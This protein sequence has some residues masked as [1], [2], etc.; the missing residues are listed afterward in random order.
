MKRFAFVHWSKHET[1]VL[2][3]L[4]TGAVL[5]GLAWALGTTLVSCALMCAWVA[6]A[7]GP[8]YNLSAF[9]TAGSIIG[10][11]AGGVAGGKASGAHGSLHGLMVGLL[12]G[13]LLVALFMAGSAWS[14]AIAGMLTRA[15]LLGIIGAAGGLFGV[16]MHDRGRG[17][18]KRKI[19][20]PRDF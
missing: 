6:L 16:N 1:P 15:V 7:S 14:F 5:T 13:A 19:F 3:K 4:K 17:S 10:A 12:Y 9:T 2:N 20:V 8:V 18:S 11:F